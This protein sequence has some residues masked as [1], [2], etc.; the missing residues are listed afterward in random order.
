MRWYLYHSVTSWVVE[1]A[2][3]PMLHQ[4][5]TLENHYKFQHLTSWVVRML[6]CLCGVCSLVLQLFLCVFFFECSLSSWDVAHQYVNWHLLHSVHW[7]LLYSVTSWVVESV[8]ASPWQSLQ[9]WAPH[10]L[11]CTL[12]Q[13]CAT[14]VE[15]ADLLISL[16]ILGY[17]WVI[18][19]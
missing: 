10:I 1:L 12:C 4:S 8:V 11:G 16:H 5:I 7:Y 6:C 15:F 18:V 9:I 14:C 17:Y 3:S 19:L 13:C 2:N